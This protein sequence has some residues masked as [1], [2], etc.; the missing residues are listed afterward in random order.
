MHYV[1]QIQIGAYLSV[2]VIVLLVRLRNCNTPRRKGDQS[3][4]V[5]EYI[6]MTFRVLLSSCIASVA[7]LCGAEALLHFPSLPLLA[8]LPVSRL[9]SM[10]DNH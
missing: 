4:K 10:P 9:S 1:L 2:A 3:Y 5:W 8:M 7:M 6:F